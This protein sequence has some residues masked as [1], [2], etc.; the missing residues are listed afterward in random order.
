MATLDA[1]FAAVD[2]AFLVI[3]ALG[4]AFLVA[5]LAETLWDVFSKRRAGLGE[6]F[7]NAA[8]G[9]GNGLL[10]TTAFGLVFVV[11][12]VAAEP[13]ALFSI[14]RNGA[15]WVLAV[16]AADLTYYWMHRLEHQ[17]R[18]LWTYHS[19]HHS[20]PEFNLTTALRLAWIEGLVE[21]VFFLP[22]ILAGFDAVQ[23]VVAFSVVV[24]YQ[25]W[26]HTEKI[27]KLG[28]ADRIFNTPSAHR[29]HHGSNRK[30]LDKNY[31]GIL[32]LWDRLFGSY[33]AEEEKVVYGITHPFGTANPLVIH[34]HEFWCLAKD[35]RRARGLGEAF[36]YIAKRP[37]WR[38]Q[39]ARGAARDQL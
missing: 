2:G 10:E 15:T 5:A 35:L 9:L 27:G 38:S 7:A 20:S 39:A 22:M 23:V 29:V 13:L 1:R 12:L 33:Q 32:I 19:V 24:A 18:L 11:A 30:Y 6:T 17:V 3:A 8:I 4:L 37:G 34:F 25:S 16:V 14:P 21:W 26:I 36:G 31:G 28:W